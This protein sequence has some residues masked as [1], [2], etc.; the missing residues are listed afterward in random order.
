MSQQDSD[1]LK[2]WQ[3]VVEAERRKCGSLLIA[4]ARC[5]GKYQEL[6]RAAF[7]R[8]EPRSDAKR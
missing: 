8:K 7:E 1:A 6:Y 4:L 5:R 2:Q 3:A